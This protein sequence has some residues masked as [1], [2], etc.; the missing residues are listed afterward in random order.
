VTTLDTPS[1]PSA[2]ASPDPRSR[3]HD[4]LGAGIGAVA[5]GLLIGAPWLVDQSGPDP[6]YKGPLIFPLI[7]LALTVL[8]AVPSAVRLVRDRRTTSWFVDGRGVPWTA[9]GLF[10]LMVFFPSAIR[11]AGLGPASFVFV[12][13]GL[14]IVG[15]RRPLRA[16]AIAAGVALCLHLAFI[17]FLDIWFPTPLLVELFEG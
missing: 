5:L 12:F 1:K 9:I 16:L 6:F 13:A 11:F 3:A 4:A 7:A 8:G 14:T 17:S 15:Y 10:A 2:T